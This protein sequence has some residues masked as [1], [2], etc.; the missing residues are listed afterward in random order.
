[1]QIKDCLLWGLA[2]LGE[3]TDEIVG[4]GARAYQ[5]GKLFIWT[6]PGYKKNNY[7]QTVYRAIKQKEIE[8]VMIKGKP[9]LRLT[10]QGRKRWQADWPL[11]QWKQ[12]PWDKQWTMVLFDISEREAHRRQ[13]LR[14]KLKQLGLG[15]LQRSCYISP[16]PMGAAIREYSDEI[17]LKKE[18]MVMTGPLLY[19]GDMKKLAFE[20]FNLKFFQQ[21]YRRLLKEGRNLIKKGSEEQWQRWQHDYLQLLIKDPCLPPELLPSDWPEKELRQCLKNHNVLYT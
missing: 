5:A 1:M 3:L 14:L 17:G 12:K 2:I 6:P 21:N 9:Y 8:R 10:E 7:R 20:V 19:S 4:G 15:M 16:Y 11:Y 18:I 13:L